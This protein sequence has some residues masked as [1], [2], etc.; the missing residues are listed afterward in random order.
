MVKGNL[1]LW[2]GGWSSG[3]F[4]ADSKIDGQVNSAR[5]SGERHFGRESLLADSADSADT[6]YK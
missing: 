5:P 2:D 3:G 4:I 6:D 1:N